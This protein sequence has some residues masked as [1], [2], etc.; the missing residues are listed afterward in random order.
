MRGRQQA[1]NQDRVEQYEARIR[2]A[3]VRLTLFRMAVPD[4]RRE[5][6]GDPL[7][8]GQAASHLTT[9]S[10]ASFWAPSAAGPTAQSSL[11]RST[12]K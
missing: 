8:R 9:V 1:R 4:P 7:G 3:A 2:E 12:P 10:G 11:Q 6:A 5:A